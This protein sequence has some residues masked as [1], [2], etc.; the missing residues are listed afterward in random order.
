MPS[1]APPSDAAARRRHV[2]T[3]AGAVD[4]AATALLLIAAGGIAAAW[5]ATD[6]SATAVLV[7]TLLY[8][9]A[10]RIT[11]SAGS[12]L[13][14]PL[15]LVFVPLWFWL[16]P[17]LLVPVAIAGNVVANRVGA[18]VRRREGPV[19]SPVSAAA[20]AWPAVAVAV[21]VGASGVSVASMSNVALVVVAV[22]GQVALWAVAHGA[23]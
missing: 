17:A 15:Q 16:P 7:G 13:A 14:T 18:W 11:F 5:P 4:L 9:A 21:V 1:E 22:L 19:P 10:L 6:V 20:D 23:R 3:R 12:G 8:A 2:P